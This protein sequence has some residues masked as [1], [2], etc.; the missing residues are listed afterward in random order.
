M[1]TGAYLMRGCESKKRHD[2]EVAARMEAI[3][4]TKLHRRAYSAYACPCCGTWHCGSKRSK[5]GYPAT[6][7]NVPGR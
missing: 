7:G 6:P 3:R 2:T 4:L 5:R 1:A